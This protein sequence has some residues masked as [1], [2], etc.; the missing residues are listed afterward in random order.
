MTD[1]G[2]S[3]AEVID[4]DVSD[5]ATSF[6]NRDLA[7]S[8]PETKANLLCAHA[9]DQVT[10]VGIKQEPSNIKQSGNQTSA[11]SAP[12]RKNTLRSIATLVKYEYCQED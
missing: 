2:F 6:T 12:D 4:L 1:V 7:S 8:S 3:E 5:P 11:E 10:Q 9:A